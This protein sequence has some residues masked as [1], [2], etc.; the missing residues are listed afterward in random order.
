MLK[1]F[2][3]VGAIFGLLQGAMLHAFIVQKNVYQ[4]YIMA[5][6]ED[7][8]ITKQQLENQLALAQK[9][10]KVD[11]QAENELKAKILD[12]MIEKKIVVKEFERMRGEF[13][14]SH[15]QKKYDFIQKA[16]FGG[17]ALGFAGALRAQGQTKF[18]YMTYLREE[19]IVE[20]MCERN[21]MRPSTVSPLEIQAYYDAHRPQLVQEKRFDVDQII[22][23]K[24][25]EEAISAIKTCLAEGAPYEESYGKLS[26]I[27]GVSASRMDDLSAGDVVP[28]I[29]EKIGTMAEN[30]FASTP[31]LCGDQM[32][33]LGLRAV[34]NAHA[35]TLAEARE[36]IECILLGEKYQSLRQRWINGLKKKSYYVIL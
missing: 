16:H 29:A 15:I 1:N 5:H 3:G 9:G 8:V 21:V 23:G 19:A 18:T 7:S 24:A 33:F 22:V 26:R 14:E 6:A 10:K 30:S 11:L 36:R 4:N 17:D 32:V 20:C 12:A 28:A 25:R 35:L 13:P 34:K 2:G 31:V 27:P